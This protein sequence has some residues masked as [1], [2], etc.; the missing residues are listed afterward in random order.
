MKTITIKLDFEDATILSYAKRRGFVEGFVKDAE[1]N[2]T[3]VALDPMDFLKEYWK[4]YIVT[5]INEY[6][7]DAV[8]EQAQ[9]QVNALKEDAVTKLTVE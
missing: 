1:G 6:I 9:L 8:W 4:Q 7:E 5:N 2:D 3:E